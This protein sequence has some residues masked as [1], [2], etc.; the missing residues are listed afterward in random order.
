M[1]DEGLDKEHVVS[2]GRNPAP[3]NEMFEPTEPSPLLRWITGSD[4]TVMN[5]MLA[6][7]INSALISNVV[8]SLK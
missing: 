5:V 4:L 6:A 1:F 7:D 8:M 2:V 3:V